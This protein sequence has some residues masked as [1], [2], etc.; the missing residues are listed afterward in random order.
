MALR[1]TTSL[2]CRVYYLPRLAPIFYQAD[3][4]VHWELSISHRRTGWLTP[5]FHYAFRELMVHAG[6]RHG[7]LCPVYCLMPEHL[8]LV[9]MGLRL[10]SN[11]LHAMAFLRTYLPP[12][13]APA[14]LQHQAYDH[15]LRDEERRRNAFAATCGYILTNP[16]EAGLV[17]R[18]ED[19]PFSGAIVP[20]YPRW[21]PRDQ[22][23]WP[24]FW[25]LYTKSKDPAAS[26]LTRP[27]DRTT[28]APGNTLE[29]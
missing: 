14:E 23:F 2:G 11:Q 19:Y 16:V 6:A 15:V 24:R 10:N 21:H 26:M 18:P 1:R 17:T 20:G 8:H 7:L 27:V 22:R 28:A 3:A 25:S 13:L 5:T 29:A 4:V 12:L 9:W